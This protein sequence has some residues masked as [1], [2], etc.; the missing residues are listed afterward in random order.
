MQ[1]SLRAYVSCLLTLLTPAWLVF[2]ELAG[3]AAFARH[4]STHSTS[5]ST[6]HS[7]SRSSRSHSR[8]RVSEQPSSRYSAR[9]S[10]SRSTHH[11]AHEERHH[12]S[13]PRYAYSADLFLA[14][15][16][17]FDTSPLP[18][19]LSATIRNAFLKGDADSYSARSLIKAGVVSYHPIRGGIFWRRQ[20]ISYVIVHSTE[21]GISQ[22][23]VRII[24]SWS[25]MGRRHPGAQFVVD[26]DGSIF[27]ALDPDLA[28]VHVNIFKTLPGINNDDSVGIEMCHTGK[29]DYPQAQ[30]DSVI[31]LVVYLQNRYHVADTNVVTHRYAQQGDHT[32]PVNFDWEGFLA[33]KN[34]LQRRALAS[35]FADLNKDALSW[36]FDNTPQPENYLQIHKRLEVVKPVVMDPDTGLPKPEKP[37]KPESNPPK[38]LMPPPT[39]STK[40]PIP[41]LRGP[42]E[43]SP[44]QATVLEKDI[45]LAPLPGS[46]P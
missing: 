45:E 32:D 6:S 3:R 31:R 17:T 37:P 30:V 1:T 8:H 19:D 24:E 20:P 41:V 11:V 9:S 22:P 35:R 44:G 26:R 38:I 34:A 40:A 33:Q 43:M 4:H 16:P 14:K 15:A 10:H 46:H 21:P 12:A 18:S 39:T 25:S 7:S 36:A 42:I 2:S 29:Q 13:H 27:E 28:T 5:A 23:A